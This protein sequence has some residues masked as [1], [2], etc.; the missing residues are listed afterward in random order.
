MK[1]WRPYTQEWTA[2]PALKVASAQGAHLSMPDGRRIF[3]GISSWW[4]I[5]HGHC[6]PEIEEAIAKQPERLAQVVFANFTHDRAEELCESLGRF[7]PRDL[8]RAFFSDNGSTAVEV[9]MKMAYQFCRQS[10]F[11][12]RTKFLALEKSYHGDTCGAMSVSRDGE[13]THNY[14]GL[15]FDIVRCNQGTRLADPEEAWVADCLD[16]LNRQAGE[17]CALILEPLLQGAG[18]MIVWPAAAVKRICE[19]ARKRGVL[20]I[21]DEVMTGFGRTGTMFAFEQLGFTPDFLCLSKGLTGGFLPMGLTVTRE[22]V[23]S[24]FLSESPNKMFF[25]GH[26][27]TGNAISCAAAVANLR[28]WEREP[29]LERLAAMNA[30][31]VEALECVPAGLPIGERRTCGPVGILELD[32]KSDY[33]GSFSR[34]VFAGSLARD[35]YVRTLG[36]TVYLMPPYCATPNEI[37]AAWSVLV[38]VVTDSLRPAK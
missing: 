8:S 22:E 32:L 13:F 25:H 3:D 10:G 12:K 21:F 35:V 23:F 33:A 7:L 31:H 34:S 4:L 14:K 26:S 18:G 37:K 36:S 11:T 20:V 9:A 27:F 17:L 6:Q 24:A 1:I 5:T 16:I 30:A 29:V 15:L 19:E 2:E 38:D 28:V